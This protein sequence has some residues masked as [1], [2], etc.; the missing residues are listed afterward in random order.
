MT[1]AAT[2]RLLQVVGDP[3]LE[4][5]VAPP[6]FIIIPWAEWQE[7]VTAVNP[8]AKS[9]DAG[10]AGPQMAE[11]PHALHARRRPHE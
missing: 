8:P 3:T 9:A 5:M 11:D 6:A 7:F 2:H 10:A 1:A 4:G